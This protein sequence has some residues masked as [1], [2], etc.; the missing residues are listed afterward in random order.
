[1]QLINV[2]SRSKRLGHFVFQVR[3]SVGCYKSNSVTHFAYAK[4]LNFVQGGG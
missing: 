1:M 3:N 4:D 2:Q